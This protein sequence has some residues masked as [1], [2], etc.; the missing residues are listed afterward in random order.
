MQITI[1][2]PETMTIESRGL[3]RPL[4]LT[5][6]NGDTLAR[7]A[8][9][10]LSQKGGDAA[11]GAAAAAVKDKFGDKAKPGDH[12]PWLESDAGKSETLKH[13]AAMI[14]KAIA[15]LESNEWTVRAASGVDGTR[16]LA[17]LRLF[18][19]AMPGDVAK[20]FAKLSASEQAAKAL[21]NAD[22]FDEA[23][24][25]AEIAKIEAE[26]QARA[27]EAAARKAEMAKLADSLDFDF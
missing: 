23:K 16:T 14:E 2:L 24:V 20:R 10:G 15:A 12:K 18:K 6:L 5:R 9:H 3:S 22:K 7:A 11:S 21:A 1:N 8:L 19:A 4:D 26:R 17:L 13:A 27:D 25:T